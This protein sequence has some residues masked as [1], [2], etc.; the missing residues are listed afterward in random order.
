[1]AGLIQILHSWGMF[2]IWIPLFFIMLFIFLF[3]L[4]YLGFTGIRKRLKLLFSIVIPLLVGIF[5][6]VF[7]ITQNFSLSFDPIDIFTNASM[8]LLVIGETLVLALLPLTLIA[9]DKS[10]LFLYNLLS[11]LPLIILGFLFDPV[12]GIL[13][14]LIFM[15]FYFPLLIIIFQHKNFFSKIKLN[16]LKIISI[17]VI[18][19]QLFRFIGMFANMKNI[20]ES[21]GEDLLFTSLTSLFIGIV[22]WSI[23]TLILFRKA[24]YFQLS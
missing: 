13:I 18:G 12:G 22:L 19:Y 16:I 24:D 1:M 21:Y 15:V 8:S 10:K 11:I 9:K 17:L 7:Y 3:L 23:F 5:L 2:D 14:L 4:A 6:S 20:F